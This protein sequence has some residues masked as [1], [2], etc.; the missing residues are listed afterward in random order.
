MAELRAN[1]VGQRAARRFRA[2]FRLS[3]RSLPRDYA[4]VHDYLHTLTG[5]LPGVWGDELRVL[6]LEI[7]IIGG[8]VALPRGLE[9]S[10]G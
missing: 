9:W 8:A 7:A 1:I 10:K 2:R 4:D 6:D 3:D 5:T